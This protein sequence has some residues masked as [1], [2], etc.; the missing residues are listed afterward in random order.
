MKLKSGHSGRGSKDLPTNE[1]D[2]TK[3][4][5]Q[6]PLNNTSVPL[7]F[8]KTKDRGETVS[9]GVDSVV[10]LSSRDGGLIKVLKW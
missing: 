2:T 7:T 3:L 4:S 8:V 1:I 10:V 5:D 9:V 6:R